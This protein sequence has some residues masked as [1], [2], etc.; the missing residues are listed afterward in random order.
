MTSRE[1]EVTGQQTRVPWES[2]PIRHFFGIMPAQW[3]AFCGSTEQAIVS[4]LGAQEL[5]EDEP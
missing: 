1:V 2:A 5:E 4:F 3:A